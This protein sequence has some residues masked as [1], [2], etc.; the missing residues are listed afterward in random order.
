M[1]MQGNP[2]DEDIERQLAVWATSQSDETLSPEVQQKVRRALGASLTP[3]KPLASQGR[4]FYFLPCSLSRRGPDRGPEQGRFPSDDW[5]QIGFMA[6]LLTVGG[7]LFSISL[8]RQ[9]VPGS[10]QAIPFSGVLAVTGVLLTAGIALLFPWRTSGSFVAV[11]LA[12]W[13]PWN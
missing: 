9:M 8:A 13:R 5:V 12:M 4:L 1:K 7:V 3:V 6:T 2:G 10:R 11:G